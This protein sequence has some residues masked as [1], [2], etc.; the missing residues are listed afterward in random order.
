[1]GDFSEGSIG[2]ILEHIEFTEEEIARFHRTISDNIRTIR[3]EKKISLLDLT[4]AIGHR[5]MSTIG[6]IE[7]RLENKHYNIEQLYK[8]ARVLRV[9]VCRF[10]GGGGN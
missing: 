9:E 5:S 4:L 3:K 6:K 2:K 1:V 8:I 10:F 7:A